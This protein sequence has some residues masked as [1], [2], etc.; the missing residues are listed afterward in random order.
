LLSFRDI[1]YFPMTWNFGVNEFSWD[2]SFD[3]E[4]G[5]VI[6]SDNIKLIQKNLPADRAKNADGTLKNNVAVTN[7]F[8]YY[9]DAK[10]RS[11][12][13][14]YPIL[15]AQNRYISSQYGHMGTG[16]LSFMPAF[17]LKTAG[18]F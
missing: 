17:T 11:C 13:L 9:E 3:G 10:D 14:L 4:N 5:L 8:V 7:A 1:T 2:Y 18:R 16:K 15:P 6:D 12:R